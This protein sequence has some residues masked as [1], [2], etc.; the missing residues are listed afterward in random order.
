MATWYSDTGIH[1]DAASRAVLEGQLSLELG[2]RSE[3]RPFVE[4]SLDGEFSL[5][6]SF[7][8]TMGLD[9]MRWMPVKFRSSAILIDYLREA[10]ISFGNWLNKVADIV[11]LLN[12]RTTSDTVYLRLLGAMIGVEFPPEDDATVDEMRKNISLAIDWYKVKGTYRAAS[13]ISMIQRYTVNIYDMWTTDYSTFV[14]VDWFAGDVGEYPPGLSSL[15][16]KS[17]HFGV[18]VLL[19]K[20]YTGGSGSVSGGTL[21]LWDAS[22]LD[23]LYEKIEEMRPVHT[24][25]HYMLLLN[26]KCDEFGHVVEVDGNILAKVTGAW[27]YSTKYLDEAWSLDDG[28]TLDTS[29]TTFLNSITKW[30]IGTGVG[31]ITAAGWDL[32]N[33][34]V[35]G[36]ID[37]SKITVLDDRIKFEFVV[38]KAVVQS[39][40]TELG[41][42]IPGSPDT[43]VAG[44]TFPVI[45]KDDRTELRVVFEIYKSDLG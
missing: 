21:F 13:I 34:V 12:A 42:Y 6:M 26:P 36:T 39:G 40:I 19:D 25:P 8:G 38:P 31:D 29:E 7:I 11:K 45:D 43:L 32:S 3:I 16:Y 27:T 37:T 24:V 20:V 33:P 5:E 9:L 14:L 41:L 23:N 15:Y 4:R 30:T 28:S 10:G 44:A 18:E 22:Y 17:P 35:S 1:S 2:E